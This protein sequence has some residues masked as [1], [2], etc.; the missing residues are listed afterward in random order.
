MLSNIWFLNSLKSQ[1]V[2]GC[3]LYLRKS[4]MSLTSLFTIWVIHEIHEWQ[5]VPFFVILSEKLVNFSVITHEI[6]EIMWFGSEREFKTWTWGEMWFGKILPITFEQFW[7][8]LP[9]SKSFQAPK[10]NVARALLSSIADLLPGLKRGSTP[11]IFEVIFKTWMRNKRIEIF[12]G[13]QIWNS[14]Q[15]QWRPNKWLNCTLVL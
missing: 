12:F 2:M 4:R 14:D 8:V 1:L 6:I 5:F 13:D 15:H 7:L 11:G 10:P 3:E 9:G